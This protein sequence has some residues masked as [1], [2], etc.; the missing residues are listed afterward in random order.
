MAKRKVES[1]GS[2]ENGGATAVVGGGEDVGALSLRGLV[3]AATSAMNP[4]AVARESARLYGEWLKIWRGNRRARS[5]SRTRGSPTPHGDLV[6]N[7]WVNNYL[8]GQDPPSFDILAWSVDGTNLPGKLHGQFL[9][10]GAVGIRAS[11]VGG[12]ELDRT[13][14]PRRSRRPARALKWNM[15]R[16]QAGHKPRADYFLESGR[17]G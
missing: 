17:T 2:R 1:E 6:W 12:W 14:A 8:T 5:P 9:D 11:R 3:D 4:L 16:L 7:Y 15:I 13:A 10:I